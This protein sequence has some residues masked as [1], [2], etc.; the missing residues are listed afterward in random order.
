MTVANTTGMSSNT[1]ARAW[2]VGVA[3]PTTTSMSSSLKSCAIEE[4]VDTSPLAFWMSTSAMMP[5]SSRA[6]TMPWAMSSRAGWAMSWEIPILMLPLSVVS[7]AAW[8]RSVDAMTSEVASI[9]SSFF[10]VCFS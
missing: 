8:A 4:A 3:I 6:S 5:S 2:A 1:F 10:I 9:V 7:P